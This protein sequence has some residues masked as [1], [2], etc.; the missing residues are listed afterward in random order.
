VFRGC[1]QPL[2]EQ[3]TKEEK[4]IQ[5]KLEQLKK[6]MHRNEQRMREAFVKYEELLA[7]RESVVSSIDALREFR[8]KK[9]RNFFRENPGVE[10][11]TEHRVS[12]HQ[13]RQ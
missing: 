8:N 4:E 10:I 5:A 2:D 6:A 12:A 11:G 13:T 1:E 3:M 7:Q 9:R